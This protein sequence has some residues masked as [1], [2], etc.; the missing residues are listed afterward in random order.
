MFSE[1]VYRSELN[2]IISRKD[3]H[4]HVEFQQLLNQV[5]HSSEENSDLFHLSLAHLSFGVM[6]IV[7]DL[8]PVA[9]RMVMQ[10]LREVERMAHLHVAVEMGVTLQD[11]LMEMQPVNPCGCCGYYEYWL[12]KHQMLDKQKIV[13]LVM[14]NCFLK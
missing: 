8:G 13:R 3:T 4:F 7:S 11:Q 10:V 12:Q 6:R 9:L 5:Q 14:N 2:I 1:S